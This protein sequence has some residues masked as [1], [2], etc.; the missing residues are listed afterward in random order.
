MN[1]T[2]ERYAKN[3]YVDEYPCCAIR[4]R[5]NELK[6]TYAEAAVKFKNAGIEKVTAEAV[7]QWVGGYSRPDMNKLL[8]IAKVL[9]CS[10][11]YLFG[12]DDLPDMD[13]S[14]MYRRTGLCSESIS[15]LSQGLKSDEPIKVSDII[16]A[17]LTNEILINYPAAHISTAASSLNKALASAG[18]WDK[19]DKFEE[20]TINDEVGKKGFV[21]LPPEAAAA[22]Y[23][24]QGRQTI[25][26]LINGYM[27]M[28][29]IKRRMGDENN[30][31]A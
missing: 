12:V 8:D 25:S 2:Q 26:D 27:D 15:T 3:K 21:A 17:I 24:H 4:K 7:R 22:Y 16:N 13:D 11:N 19:Y 29:L 6:W 5:I 1:A 10:I 28:M 30:G 18:H 9:D 31:K 20:K 23:L 14:E